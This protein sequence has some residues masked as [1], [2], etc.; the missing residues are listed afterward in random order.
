MWLP[1]GF[2]KSPCHEIL[3]FVFDYKLGLIGSAKSSAV[4]VS[5]LV[6]VMFDQVQKL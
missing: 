5:P 2:G 3:P 4:L 6:S 1:T